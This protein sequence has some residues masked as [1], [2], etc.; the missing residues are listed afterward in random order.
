[1]RFL[2]AFA[3]AVASVTSIASADPQ[4]SPTQQASEHFDR[5]VAMYNEADY[6]AAL[7]EFRKAYEIAPNAAVLYNLGQ[8][9]YQLQNYAQALTA[10][11]RYLAESGDSP[12]HK[13]E[14]E[15]II[16]TLKSRVGKL[17]V[18]TSLPDAEITIDD[19]L[20]GKTPLTAAIDVSIGHRKVT[21]LRAGKPAETRYVDVAAGELVKVSIEF[22]TAA[23]T[24]ISTHVAG[25]SVATGDGRD[26][27][28]LIVGGWVAT[29]ILAAGAGTMG[30]VA[31]NASS[32][33]QTAR[34]TF[35]ETASDLKDKASRV[36][37]F[38]AI[39]DALTAAAI[40]TGGVALYFTLTRT[41]NHEV[42]VA[43]LPG[44]AMLA[45]SFK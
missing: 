35:P 6:R 5:G 23:D 7:V 10:F 8:T 37:T 3:V 33:L 31:W 17:L 22:V 19:E 45:G 27:R 11:T 12:S 4:A 44:G 43:L 1:M 39:A 34:S 40:V 28:S 25:P 21:A 9:Y 14:V 29:G 26:H 30:L 42:H 41:K 38:S 16:S 2:L 15:G 13:A 20:A 32:T 18:T 24:D 36:T